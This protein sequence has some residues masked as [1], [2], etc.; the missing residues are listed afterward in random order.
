MLAA[1][2]HGEILRLVRT[3]GSARTRDLAPALDCAEETIRRD[4]DKLAEDGLLVRSHGGAIAVG[5]LEGDLQHRMREARFVEEKKRIGRLA[6]ACIK[7]H[8]SILLDESSTALAMVDFLPAEFSLRVV[9]SSLLVAQRVAAGNRHELVQLG[10]TFDPVSLSF[11]GLLTELAVSRLR[12][13]RFFFSCTGMHP[14]QG[15]AEPS[16]DRARTKMHMLGLSAFNCVL[17]DHSKLGARAAHVFAMPEE[18]DQ[19]VTDQQPE[20]E[21]AAALDAADIKFLSP[22]AG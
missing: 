22:G 11:G 21:F 2:R 20:P 19:L 4:L 9:T 1:D 7:P 18:I 10:G 17:A 13:D 8:E 6:A 16:E 3:A 5:G 14:V 12:I 15:A